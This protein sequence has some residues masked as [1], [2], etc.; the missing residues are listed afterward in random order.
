M[1]SVDKE[2]VD[3]YFVKACLDNEYAQRYLQNCS[4][5]SAVAM[6]SYKDLESLPIPGLPMARQKEIGSRCRANVM[7]VVELRDRLA[8]AR[9]SLGAVLSEAAPECFTASR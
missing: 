2:Q 1:I 6:L 8:V 4:V 3:P 5:G 9:K 7:E